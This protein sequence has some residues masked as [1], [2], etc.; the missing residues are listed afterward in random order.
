MVEN[1]HERTTITSQDFDGF[2]CEVAAAVW[3]EITRSP[4][5]HGLKPQEYAAFFDAVREVLTKY[6]VG[7]KPCGNRLP[8]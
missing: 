3:N 4:K 6:R 5:F 8:E 2:V 1:H 7:G